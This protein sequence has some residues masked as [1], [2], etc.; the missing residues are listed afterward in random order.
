MGTNGPTWPG[1]SPS[2]SARLIVFFLFPRNQ[3]ERRM[4][5]EYAAEDAAAESESPA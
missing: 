5:A 1:S 4:L 2:Y 3:A